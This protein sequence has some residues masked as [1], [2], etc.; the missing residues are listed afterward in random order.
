MGDS[1]PHAARPLAAVILAAGKGTRM[2]SAKHKVL[3]PLAG[4][5]MIE[6]LLAA[7]GEL[8]PERT[9]V[10]VGEGREQLEAALAGRAAFA[11]QEPQLGTGHAVQQAE[12]ALEGFEG[13]VLVLYGDVPLVRAATMRA[14]IARLHAPDAPEAVV[15]AFEPD[16]PLQYGRVL[17][18]GDKITWMVEHK[19]ADEGQRACRLCNSGL[20]AARAETLFALL[21]QVLGTVL[22]IRPELVYH[23]LGTAMVIAGVALTWSL[24]RLVLAGWSAYIR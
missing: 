6:H 19:D 16:D 21:A 2:K 15:L 20:L 12:A 10:V 14:L 3:H 8:Q 4:R 24:L 1:A 5:P 7:L 23:A 9:V 18:T 17:A 22:A 13:D 11:V